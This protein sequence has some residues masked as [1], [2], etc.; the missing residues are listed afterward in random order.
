V[1]RAERERVGHH[2]DLS[3]AIMDSQSVT[4]VEESARIRGYDAYQRVKGRKRHPLVDTH[5]QPIVWYVTPADLSD[6]QG[7]NRLPG[8]P[9]FFMPCPRKTWAAAAYRGKELAEWCR[10]QGAGWEIEIV[11]HEPGL[12]GCRVQPRRRIVERIFARLIR[13][14]HSAKDDE[15]E[16]QLSETRI[17]LAASHLLLRRLAS[18]R[19]ASPRLA[20]PVTPGAGN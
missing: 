10:L 5:G 11:E 19:L 2:P 20:S 18:P 13:N 8:G 6:P 15:R 3:A 7:A 16:M 12:R 9:A 17:E 1:H 4:T 14:R